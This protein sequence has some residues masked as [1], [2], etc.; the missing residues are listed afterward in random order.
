MSLPFAVNVKYYRKFSLALY[1]LYRRISSVFLLHQDIKPS[2]PHQARS[3]FG[4]GCFSIFLTILFIR[5][6]GSV[7]E[8]NVAKVINGIEA[9]VLAH[10]EHLGNRIDIDVDAVRE[11]VSLCNDFLFA[12]GVDTSCALGL[13]GFAKLAKED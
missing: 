3:S 11:T 2:T 13:G 7:F 10:V 9:N 4:M 8:L 6:C 1:F 5:A 12:M